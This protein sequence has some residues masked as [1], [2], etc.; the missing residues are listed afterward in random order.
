MITE[1]GR[2]LAGDLKSICIERPLNGYKPLRKKV[3][4]GRSYI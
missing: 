4:V 1:S 2:L 3:N